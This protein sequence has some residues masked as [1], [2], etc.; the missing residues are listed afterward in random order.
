MSENTKQSSKASTGQ[1]KAVSPPLQP[2]APPLVGETKEA[3]GQEVD[4]TKFITQP[5][6][7][8]LMQDFLNKSKSYADH[9]RVRL[10]SQVKA[11]LQEL[12]FIQKQINASQP[13]QEQT[14]PESNLPDR[15]AR[16]PGVGLIS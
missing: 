15:L 7:E 16:T 12:E 6:I 11:L 3:A 14:I 5:E 2:L 1:L 10:E 8:L 4:M 13:G 9:A